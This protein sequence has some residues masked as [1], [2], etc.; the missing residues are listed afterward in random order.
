MGKMVKPKV[1]AFV[2]ILAFVIAGALTCF[3]K[4]K[5]T[6]P[7]QR[8]LI[9]NL[10][11]ESILQRATIKGVN[12]KKGVWLLKADKVLS[13]EKLSEIRFISPNLLITLNNNSTI[14]L[15]AQNG[16]YY[17][18]LKRIEFEHKIK[19]KYKDII[20]DANFM[21]FNLKL[22]KITFKNGIKI[23]NKQLT[24]RGLEGIIDLNNH[25][26]TIKKNV[27]VTII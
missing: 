6:H 26:I 13:R 11:F 15:R 18:E 21:K 24:V 19:G 20:L 25:T 12:K 5:Q 16:I 4:S 2:L 7:R 8:F 10:P 9:K 27:R 17:R 22:N 14:K 1:L 3:Q 23:S